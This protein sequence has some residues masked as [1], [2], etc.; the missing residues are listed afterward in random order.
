LI[1][2]VLF[3]ILV[4][5][6]YWQLS[7]N[8]RRG[9]LL[10]VALVLFL[11]SLVLDPQLQISIW[12]TKLSLVPYLDDWLAASPRNMKMLAGLSGL[13]RLSGFIGVI[14]G[15]FDLLRRRKPRIADPYEASSGS[16]NEQ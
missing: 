7:H 4:N 8:A 11:I 15:I 3:F 10:L 12:G 2:G 14:W 5:V 9:S 16:T 6:G 1:F 13:L